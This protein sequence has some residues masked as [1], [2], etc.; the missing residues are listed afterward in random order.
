MAATTLSSRQIVAGQLL[1]WATRVG[2]GVIGV[3]VVLAF[4]PDPA[5]GVAARVGEDLAAN[6]C[7]R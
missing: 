1:W 2:I 5:A 7:R 3:G 6:P 4:V